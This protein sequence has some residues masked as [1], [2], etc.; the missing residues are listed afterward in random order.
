MTFDL[1]SRGAVFWPVGTGDSTTIV[2]NDTIVIQVDLHDLVKAQEDGTPHTPVVDELVAALP[3]IDGEPYLA[4]FALT[5]ADKD[6]CQGFADLLGRV[7]IGEL[8]ATPRMWRELADPDAPNPCPDAIAFQK[9]AERRVAAT[10]DALAK[11]QEPGSGDRILVIGY[12]S[13]HDE[14]AYSELPDKYLSGPGKAVTVLDDH[15]CAEWFEAFFHAPFVD[16]CA[17]ERNETSLAMQITLSDGLGTAKIL[18]L[19]DLAHDT[20]MKIITYSEGHERSERLEWDLLLAPHHCSK[21]VMYVSDDGKDVPQQDVLDAFT[22]YAR[23]DDA[24]IVSSSEPIPAKDEPG[25]NPPHLMAAN[26]YREIAQFICTMSWGSETAPSPV[27]LGVDMAGAHVLEVSAEALTAI[28][29]ATSPIVRRMVAV[30]SAAASLAGTLATPAISA[31]ASTGPERVRAAV[32][33]DRGGACAPGS[34]VGF[35]R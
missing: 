7:R 28:D 10:K 2:L 21:K 4:V 30:T 16:D 8:W 11:G 14:H 22:R 20:I 18:L 15:D 34:P 27:V 3:E 32:A 31:P 19:G 6:H 17:A 33:A 25:K 24:V 12:D 13:D 35:G 5:H 29:R 23:S 1:P 9:E 26:R